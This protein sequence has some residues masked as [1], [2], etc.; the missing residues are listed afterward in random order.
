[1]SPLQLS[2][3]QRHRHVLR[4]GHSCL[5]SFGRPQFEPVKHSLAVI[6]P[7]TTSGPRFAVRQTREQPQLD[8]LRPVRS[9]R[10]C[11]GGCR[12]TTPL[13]PILDPILEPQLEPRRSPA[14][15]GRE[16][17]FARRL[18][19]E[20]YLRPRPCPPNGAAD[21]PQ[22]SSSSRRSRFGDRLGPLGPRRVPGLTETV[23]RPCP[24]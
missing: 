3:L 16:S 23:G 15:S 8:G 11:T 19:E 1:M 7:R 14:A 4:S 24:Y 10:H 12:W 22:G 20:L 17:R 13:E 18:F 5:Q 9:Q 21:S 2:P 6:C